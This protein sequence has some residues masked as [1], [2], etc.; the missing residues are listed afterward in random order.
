MLVDYLLLKVDYL[1]LSGSHMVEFKS[2]DPWINPGFRL[3]SPDNNKSK[4]TYK[5]DTVFTF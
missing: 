2:G 5:I 4:G 1:L 3:T